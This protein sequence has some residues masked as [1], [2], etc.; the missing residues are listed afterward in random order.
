MPFFVNISAGIDR[1]EKVGDNK[2]MIPGK[3]WGI[4]PEKECKNPFEM[5]K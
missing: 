1:G 5:V 3:I 4:S 2:E